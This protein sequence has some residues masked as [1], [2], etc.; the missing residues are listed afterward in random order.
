M[1]DQQ[2]VF[3]AA[4]GQAMRE[5]MRRDETIF[6]VGED[7]AGSGGVFKCSEGLLA[8]FGTRAPFWAAVPPPKASASW[9]ARLVRKA[10][11]EK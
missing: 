9:N 3:R 8:E 1:P 6:L 10:R 5:E 11:W 7:V 4:V 2:L